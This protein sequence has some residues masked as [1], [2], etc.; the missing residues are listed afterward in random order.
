M[1]ESEFDCGWI[2]DEICEN[3]KWWSAQYKE[4]YSDHPAEGNCFES[5]YE[6]EI[7]QDGRF[8]K[9]TSGD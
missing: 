9:Q 3:C 1:G 5:A 2:E 4:C 8:D 6:S 7:D